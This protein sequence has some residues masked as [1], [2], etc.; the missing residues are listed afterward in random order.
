MSRIVSRVT[1]EKN[2]R[3]CR[4]RRSL[5]RARARGDHRAIE[6]RDATRRDATMDGARV[7]SNS[8]S[9]ARRRANAN[10]TPTRDGENDGFYGS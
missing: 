5:G 7:R 10:A 2:A 1:R 8:R 3:A 4:P 9:F 6:R